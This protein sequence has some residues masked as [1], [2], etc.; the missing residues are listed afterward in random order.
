MKK[1]TMK[2]A[3]LMLSAFTL[4]GCSNN[5]PYIGENG[6]WW[7]GDSDLG[8]PAT[9]PQGEPGQQ[10]PQGEPGEGVTVTSVEKTGTNGN[11]DTYTITYSDGTTTTFT[12]TNGKNG[13]DGDSITVTD[14]SI[15]SSNNGVDTYTITFSD[16][17]TATFTVTNGKDLTVISIEKVGSSGLCDTYRITFSNGTYSEFVVKNGATP[18]IGENGNWWID[19][20]DTGVLADSTREDKREIT[21]EQKIMS[22]GLKYELKTVNGNYGYFVIGYDTLMDQGDYYLY[23]DDISYDDYI[24]IGDGIESHTK[25]LDIVIPNYIG[26]IPVIGI[27]DEA[28]KNN[29]YLGTVSLS[30][31]TLYLGQETF[32]SC[33]NL[34]SIDFNGSNVKSLGNKCFYNDS[35]FVNADFP[36]SLTYIGKRALYGCHIDYFDFSNVKYI[37]DEAFYGYNKNVYL[38]TNVEYVGSK[39]FGSAYLFI[40]HD[41]IPST[42][43]E[44]INGELSTYNYVSK[45]VTGCRKNDEFIYSVKNG[46]A[47]LHSYLGGEEKLRLP[48]TVDDI[49]AEAVG[50]GFNSYVFFEEED[51]FNIPEGYLHEVIVP[52]SYKRIE[53]GALLCNGMFIYVE[54]GVEEVWGGIGFEYT[55]DL[56]LGVNIFENSSSITFSFEGETYSYEQFVALDDETW[57]RNYSGISYE[58]IYYDEATKTYFQKEGSTYTALACLDFLGS[59]IEIPNIVNGLPVTQL[60]RFS[61]CATSARKY[62]IGDNVKKIR[63]YAFGEYNLDIY[64]GKIYVYVPG[65][66]EIINSEAFCFS[67]SKV[68]YYVSATSKP[69]DWDSNWCDGA[70]NIIY[71]A[72]REDVENIG[73]YENFDYTISNNEITLTKYNGSSSEIKIPRTINGKAVVKI[74]SGFMSRSSSITTE[75]FIPNS[76]TT[77][78]AN[79]FTNSY[80]GTFVFYF[81]TS[82]KSEGISSSYYYNSYYGSY[83][84]F[85][86]ERFNTAFG[87]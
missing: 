58:D 34:Y 67:S 70:S 4:V 50:Y 11:V 29:D 74:A 9:G 32:S 24:R 56:K 38:T 42:W 6:N 37:G 87:Y 75:V 27:G 23:A 60:G 16:G 59:S 82:S 10:G 18:Y 72:Q 39:A 13:D 5:T 36:Q 55:I 78:E 45:V 25:Y 54:S 62:L 65:S 2:L 86:E 20:V 1:K 52:S 12:V 79:A 14:V 31:N 46:K 63:S 33:D 47:T 64:S 8:V 77:I 43:G 26:N 61:Y 53:E 40:E 83:S 85:K 35:K 73:V 44:N 68:Q 76:V 57:F 19:G 81:E 80:Y 41:E 17:T 7:V 30:K 15:T 69:E 28:F 71:N 22:S 3:L 51:C 84:E 49:T 48:E 66:V 21:I